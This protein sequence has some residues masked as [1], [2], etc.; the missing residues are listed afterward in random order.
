MRKS[1]ILRKGLTGKFSVLNYSM[2]EKVIEFRI[3]I[4]GK[5][6]WRIKDSLNTIIEKGTNKIITVIL[7]Y[8]KLP[9]RCESKMKIFHTADIKKYGV[10]R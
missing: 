6:I 10:N 8:P 5:D 7:N 3:C 2:Q 1:E 9:K 4:S